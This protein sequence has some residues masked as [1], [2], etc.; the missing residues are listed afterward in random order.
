MTAAE[1]KEG[2]RS[3]QQMHTALGKQSEREADSL[4]PAHLSPRLWVRLFFYS[5]VRL[6]CVALN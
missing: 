1:I 5:L 3:I 2:V 4:S 6:Q